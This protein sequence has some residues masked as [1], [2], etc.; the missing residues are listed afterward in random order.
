[1]QLRD[2]I[3]L[4]LYAVLC[5]AVLAV[6]HAAMRLQPHLV[7]RCREPALLIQQVQYAHLALNKVQHILVVHKLDVAPVNALTLVFSLQYAK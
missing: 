1:M 6:L 2:M 3:L 4:L 5:C 7:R